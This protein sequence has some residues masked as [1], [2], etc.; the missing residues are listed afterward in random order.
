[1]ET[2]VTIILSHALSSRIC[3]VK[4]ENTI[5]RDDIV[6]G[7]LSENTMSTASILFLFNFQSSNIRLIA[8]RMTG[9]MRLFYIFQDQHNCGRTS[10]GHNKFEIHSKN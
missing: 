10:S 1:M 4:Q 7:K 9:L 2:A 5:R 6:E 3:I 8:G